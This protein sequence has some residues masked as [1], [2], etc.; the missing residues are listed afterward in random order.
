MSLSFHP[1][2]TRALPNPRSRTSPIIT[3]SSRPR[4]TRANFPNQSQK[5]STLELSAK[6]EEEE[7]TE[8]EELLTNQSQFDA[9]PRSRPSP[10]IASSRI[11]PARTSFL[12]RSQR[13]STAGSSAKLEEQEVSEVEDLLTD[14]SEFDADPRSRASPT[15]APSRPRPAHASLLN[16]SQKASTPASSAK[17]EE[18]EVTEVEDLLTNQSQFDADPHSRT[19]PIIA[20]RSRPVHASFLNRPQKAS[21]PGSSAKVEEQEATEVEEL[22]SKQSQFD[23]DAS[24][25]ASLIQDPNTSANVSRPSSNTSSGMQH[26]NASLE[27]SADP[28]PEEEPLSDEEIE[29][30]VKGGELIE[31][32]QMQPSA[33]WEFGLTPLKTPFKP[34]SIRPSRQSTPKS[35]TG[36]LRSSPSLGKYTSLMNTSNPRFDSEGESCKSHVYIF[37]KSLDIIMFSRRWSASKHVEVQRQGKG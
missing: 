36:S 30:I 1:S 2:P 17:V 6:V 18:Q 3:P 35:L 10:I 29:E 8:V 27:P 34:G 32:E 15:I 21:T 22:L 4:L 37:P 23:V 26:N 13:A 31:D 14:Q 20:S 16:G 7:V 9:D 12:N 33:S 24:R 19:S 25:L 11:R 5:T 28:A